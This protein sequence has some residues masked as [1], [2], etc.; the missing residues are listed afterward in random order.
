VLRRFN[1]PHTIKMFEFIDTAT[2]IFM[3]LEYAAG[4]ELFDL[5]ARRERLDEQEARKLF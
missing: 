4:G 2:E 5:I 1:N 3:V